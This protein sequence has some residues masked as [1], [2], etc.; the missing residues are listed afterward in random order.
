[1][2]PT[3]PLGVQGPS[4]RALNK[5]DE[6]EKPKESVR[7]FSTTTSGDGDTMKWTEN[8]YGSGRCEEEVEEG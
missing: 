4:V 6:Q 5:I 7:Q 1:M 3:R 8:T 2:E